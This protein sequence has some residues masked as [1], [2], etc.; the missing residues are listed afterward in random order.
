M[1]ANLLHG[2]PSSWVVSIAL[3]LTT[4]LGSAWGEE[5]PKLGENV[6]FRGALDNCRLQF[7]RQKKGHVAFIGGSIT[8]M[9]GYRPMVCDILKRR[10]PD[11]QFT[12]TD[13]GISSTCSTTGAFRL[14]TDVLDQGPV[15]LF[16]VEFAVNDDQDA[17]HTRAECIRGMEGLVRQALRHN[18]NMDIVITYFVNPEMLATIRSGKTPLPIAAHEDVAAHYGIATIDLAREVAQRIAVGRLTWEKYGG[19]HPAPFG[20]AICAGMID[21]LMGWAWRKPA[22]AAAPVAHPLPDPLD[23][24][25]YQNG[26]FLDLKLAQHDDGWRLDVPEWKKLKGGTRGRFTKIPMLW[27]DRPGAELTLSFTGTA[28]GAYVVAGPDAGMVEARV[29]DRPPQEVD[30]YHRFSAGLHY[31]RTVMLGT[32][33]PPGE[34]T[35]RLRVIEKTRSA[36]HAARIMQFTAN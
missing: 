17:A 13:A 35:L 21:E 16:F 10:F 19:V 14:K 5:I 33:L 11:T 8:E 7:Q 6:H 12:F 2:R 29:D 31:P 26:R 4:C 3:G 9:N 27:A 22:A 36:G 23:P 1:R 25:C 18:P 28:I 15:D 32:D 24:L 20:N 34:H 30:L